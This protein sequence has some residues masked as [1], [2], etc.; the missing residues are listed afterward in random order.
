[1][2]EAEIKEKCNEDR[3]FHEWIIS[4]WRFDSRNR[5]GLTE[6]FHPRIQEA[7]V[8]MCIFCLKKK[9]IV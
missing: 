4:E 1:M 5:N 6:N 8:V 3:L 7:V 9:E 2:N